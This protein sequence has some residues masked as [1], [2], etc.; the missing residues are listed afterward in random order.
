MSAKRVNSESEAKAPS[1][2]LRVAKVDEQRRDGDW[3]VTGEL[4]TVTNKTF[5]FSKKA[6]MTALTV[7][8]KNECGENLLTCCIRNYG[9]YICAFTCTN[10]GEFENHLLRHAFSSRH[11]YTDVCCLCKTYALNKD[12]MPD[13]FLTAHGLEVAEVASMIGHPCPFIFAPEQQ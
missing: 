1:K 11:D 3:I 2:I 6:V 5:Q 13:H 9:A 10:E 12:E 7:N 8:A 4:N